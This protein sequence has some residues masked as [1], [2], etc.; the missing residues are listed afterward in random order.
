MMFS[1]IC[2]RGRVLYEVTIYGVKNRNVFAY[3][4]VMIYHRRS[5]S[6]MCR[7]CL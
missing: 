3:M 2:D 4:I 6:L 5:V 7:G 1:V